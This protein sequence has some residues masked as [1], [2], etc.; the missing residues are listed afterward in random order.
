MIQPIPSMHD[1]VESGM[2]PV[3]PPLYRRL[4]GRPKKLRRK[5]DELPNSSRVS[6]GI[7]Q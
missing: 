3:D 1:W 6:E 5:V 4:A 7:K 2:E